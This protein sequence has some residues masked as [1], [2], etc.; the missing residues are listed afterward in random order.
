MSPSGSSNKYAT[1]RGVYTANRGKG[2][3]HSVNRF[4]MLHGPGVGREPGLSFGLYDRGSIPGR[5]WDFFSS[6][7][8]PDL[9]PT[10]PPIQCVPEVKQ[11]GREADHSPPS[12][13][14]F[15][16]AWSYTSTPIRLHGVVLS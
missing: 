3:G 4:R 14:E 11:P 7:P 6:S 1:S 8:L 9:G 10:Q 2:C 12:S 16:N 15:K 13:S 5:G